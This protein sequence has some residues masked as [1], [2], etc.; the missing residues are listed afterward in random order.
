[1]PG[2]FTTGEKL[3]TPVFGSPNFFGFRRLKPIDPPDGL[4]AGFIP[5]FGGFGLTF[6]ANSLSFP[7]PSP[8]TVDLPARARPSSAPKNFR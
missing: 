1:M 4:M 6:V 7:S 2:G 5:G 8:V 3:P